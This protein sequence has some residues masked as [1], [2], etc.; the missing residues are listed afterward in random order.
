MKKT[1]SKKSDKW[2]LEVTTEQA[3]LIQQAVEHMARILAGQLS[4]VRS[5]VVFRPR[6]VENVEELADYP[7]NEKIDKA[8]HDLKASL[9]PELHPNASYGVGSK[10]CHPD[11]HRYW[12]LYQIIRRPLFLDRTKDTAKE[13]SYSVLGNSFMQ[14]SDLP[15]ALFKKLEQ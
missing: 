13:D 12:D 6:K 14:T 4:E 5:A 15:P 2:I 7:D 3:Y 11:C 9:F 10:E 1:K 8:L